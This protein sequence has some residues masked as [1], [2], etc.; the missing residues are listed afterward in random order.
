MCVQGAGPFVWGDAE[1]FGGSCSI[2]SVEWESCV[3]VVQWPRTSPFHGG[4]TGSNPVGD[5]KDSKEPT[6]VFDAKNEGTEG[7]CRR[8]ADRST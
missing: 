6:S 3:P 2:H 5:A 8:L 7:L 4:N 1:A